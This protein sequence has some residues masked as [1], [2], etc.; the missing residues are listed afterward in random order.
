MASAPA[1]PVAA[2]EI[3]REL[4]PQ[5]KAFRQPGDRGARAQRCPR[6]MA[7]GEQEGCAVS[8]STVLCFLL[9][10]LIEQTLLILTLLIL[11]V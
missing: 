5:T 9:L 6:G 2:L 1:R 3:E 8:C 10:L 4:T 7:Q 11:S